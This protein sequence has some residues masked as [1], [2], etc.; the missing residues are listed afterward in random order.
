MNKAVIRYIWMLAVMTMLTALFQ[1]ELA[2]IILACVFTVAALIFPAKV[3]FLSAFICTVLY[4]LMSEDMAGGTIMALSLILP[5]AAMSMAVKRG[6]TLSTVLGAGTLARALGLF[7]YYYYESVIRHTTIQNLL[8]GDFPENLLEQ[9]T[10]VGY[11]N[12][13][14]N[15]LQSAWSYMENLIPA[16]VLTSS[17]V[18]AF[19][20]FAAVKSMVKRSGIRFSSIRNFKDM[21][22]DKMFTV[23]ALILFVSAFFSGGAV[24]IITLNALYFMYVIYLACGAAAF[25]RFLKNIVKKNSAVGII[26]AI[27]GIFT[28]GTVFV[29]V[30][31]ISSF[32]GKS[33][34]R[35]RNDIK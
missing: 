35:E 2:M 12:A 29:P 11:S 32:T 23:F 33:E 27:T 1:S 6:Q 16:I 25:V 5:A 8:V 14:I 19:L 21:R 9:M 13:Q 31:I 28:F 20:T 15:I 4:A 7:G 34:N 22:A 24:N 10:Q 17:L 18:F 30:G 3:T 26:T